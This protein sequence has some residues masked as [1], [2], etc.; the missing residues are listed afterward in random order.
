MAFCTD[1]NYYKN[2]YWDDTTSL[3]NRK[4]LFIELE[5]QTN[6]GL[7]FHFIVCSINRF[8]TVNRWYGYEVSDQILHSFAT[9]FQ[10]YFTEDVFI[11][12]LGGDE[13]GIITYQSHEEI[14]LILFELLEYISLQQSKH[15]SHFTI[16]LSC[17]MSEYLTD[18]KEVS[19]LVDYA[20]LALEERKTNQR[21][22]VQSFKKMKTTNTLLELQVEKEFPSM[23]SKKEAYLVYQ[24]IID[25]T[26]HKIVHFEAL[27]RWN[28]VNLGM[29]SPATFIPIAEQNGFIHE[30]TEYL[31]IQVIQDLLV[32]NKDH[33]YKV[34]LN[35]SVQQLHNDKLYKLLTFALLKGIKPHWMGIEIIE[36]ETLVHSKKAIEQLN[37]IHHLGIEIAIDDYGA[38]YTSLSYLTRFPVSTLKIDRSLIIQIEDPSVISVLKGLLL[39][40]NEIGQKIVA[41]GVETKK[42]F[43]LLHALGIHYVQGYLFSRPLTLE[44][45]VEL[46][47]QQ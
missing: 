13:F 38:G 6:T 10:K 7:P 23:L 22:S 40:C 1:R 16:T 47:K 24:P 11:A 9:L 37:K 18:T 20:Y 35:I 15:K 4:A 19:E 5:K 8:K 29:I 25:V 34:T 30:I 44:P 26:T 41:E 2:L 43:T 21:S 46:V 17:G 27:L 28:N 14:N 31:I 42:Q 3:P 33:N 36:T 12:R 39:S 32:L 45:L